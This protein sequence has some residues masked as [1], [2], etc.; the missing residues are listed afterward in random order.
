MITTKF[1]S[2]FGRE[3]NELEFGE[4]I[5]LVMEN[6]EATGHEDFDEDELQE[7]ESEEEEDLEDDAA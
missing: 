2:R 6:G 5:T 7:E 3:W 4:T 1:R